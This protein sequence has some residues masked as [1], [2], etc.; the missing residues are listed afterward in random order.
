MTR[1]LDMMPPPTEQDALSLVGCT[2]GDV[3]DGRWPQ[4]LVDMVRV[5]EAVYLRMG[6]S[7][8]DA[9]ALAS[10]GV[11]AVAEYFGAR[12]W[13][14]PRGDRLRIALRDAEIFRKAKRGNVRD[15]ADAFRLSEPQIYRIIREQHA[16]HLSKIQGRLFED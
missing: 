15:L 7:E 13:Y 8:D 5:Q 1:Q 10:Q 12:M 14:L 16:L 6:R 11:M 9:F 3:P 2:P 4:T